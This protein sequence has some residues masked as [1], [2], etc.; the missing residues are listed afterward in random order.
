MRTSYHNPKYNTRISSIATDAVLVKR[1]NWRKIKKEATHLTPEQIAEIRR[2]QDEEKMTTMSAIQT[3]RTSL[4][5][6][7]IT[8][9]TL[10]N[11]RTKLL[12][13]EEREPAL[14]IKDELDDEEL[15]EIKF[16]RSQMA[17]AE[18][19][20]LR[21][22][23]LIEN[24]E[25]REKKKEEEKEW[26]RKL[27]ENRIIAVKLYDDRE[28][29]LRE[30]RIKGRAIIQ[31]QIEEKKINKILEAERIDRERKA[32]LEQNERI[33]EEDRRILMEKKKR[34]QDFLHDCLQAN[35]AQRKR[36]QELRE[37]EK[38]EA[39][40]VI[41]V[42]AQKAL[43]EEA[44]EKEQALEHALFE[45]KWAEARKKQ[46]RITDMQSIRDEKAAIKVQKEKEEK[47]RLREERDIAKKAQ[48]VREAKLGCDEMIELKRKRLIEQKKIEDAEYQRVMEAN[49]IAREKARREYEK[50]IE[51]D[52]QY[53]NEL[54]LDVE[55]RWE[56]N[57]IDPAKKVAEA[58]KSKEENEAYLA[59]LDTIR[60]KKLNILRNKG[61]PEKYLVDIMAN[62]W[63]IK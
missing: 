23:Q 38:E 12:Q 13:T 63:Q 39:Q 4:I 44:R 1:D 21:D 7:E 37:R 61:V 24:V 8:K 40:M 2:K 30:Q 60:E 55:A 34:Q 3:K 42:A 48:M 27:E 35:E 53:R 26:A 15:D 45:R 62:K 10:L 59:R 41:E 33:A 31:A 18:A 14:K 47:D 5:K 25:I 6:P 43:D 58:Q 57:K 32:M 49:R 16:V 50:K 29:T 54:R 17:A 28:K 36:K 52:N 20:T 19:R 46:K 56:A 11:T 22:K 9:Q 51:L